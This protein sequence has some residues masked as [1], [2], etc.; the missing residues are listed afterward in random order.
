MSDNTHDVVGGE[1]GDGPERQTYSQGHLSL[2]K[3]EPDNAEHTADLVEDET[4]QPDAPPPSDSEA[5][6]IVEL[7]ETLLG[8]AR[9]CRRRAPRPRRHPERARGRGRR[10][11]RWERRCSRRRQSWAEPIQD[12]ADGGISDSSVVPWTHG[13]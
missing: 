8:T 13:R 6:Q 7:G 12:R 3:G 10:R 5:A 1:P 4:L 9:R 2:N 11:G